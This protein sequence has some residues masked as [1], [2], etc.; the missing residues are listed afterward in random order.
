MKT[1]KRTPNYVIQMNEIETNKKNLRQINETEINP[2][3]VNSDENQAILLLVFFPFFFLFFIFPPSS[4]A[5]V[6]TLE[7]ESP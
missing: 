4:T 7:R 5:E 2:N 6:A 1:I 3:L